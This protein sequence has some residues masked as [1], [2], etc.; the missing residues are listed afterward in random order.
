MRR[1]PLCDAVPLVLWQVRQ[2]QTLPRSPPSPGAT[3]IALIVAP[4]IA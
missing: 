3:L 1:V 2:S 4:V